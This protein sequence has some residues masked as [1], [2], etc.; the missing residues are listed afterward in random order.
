M[1]DATRWQRP[2]KINEYL[3]AGRPVVCTDLPEIRRD[4]GT[5]VALAS[6]TEAFVEACY[7]ALGKPDRGLIEATRRGLAK[8]DWKH[9]T[10]A[11]E[12]HIAAALERAGA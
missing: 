10:E 1:N 12:A 3:M 8:T 2:V 7:H 5:R 11:I 9:T 6:S 4:F